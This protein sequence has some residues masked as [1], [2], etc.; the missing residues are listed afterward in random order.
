MTAKIDLS[1]LREGALLVEKVHEAWHQAV[2]SDLT[3][4]DVAEAVGTDR[5]KILSRVR[6]LRTRK[7]L[8]MPALRDEGRSGGGPVDY[9][10]L[11]AR[12]EQIAKGTGKK[13]P[14]GK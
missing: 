8:D 12:G 1:K 6:K 14:K 5:R 9:D 13:A 4:D 11:K 10:A 3:V 2:A 7:G